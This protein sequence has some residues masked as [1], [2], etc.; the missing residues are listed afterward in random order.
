VVTALLVF[1]ITYLFVGLTQVPRI[2]ISRPAGAL[3]GSV[4]MVVTGVLTLD[5]AF[6]AVDMHTLLLLLG[7]MIITVYLRRAGFFELMAER[8]LSLART[9]VQLLLLVSLASA[10]LSAL[11]VNDTICLLFTPVLLEVTAQ[12]GVNPVP[13]LLALATSSNIGSVMTVTGNPQNMLIGIASGIP[14]LAFL[15]SLAPVALIGMT[16]SIGVIRL[17]YRGEITKQPFPRP[18]R[19]RIAPS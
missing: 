15:R 11:F 17:L 6:A 18:A 2:P 13:Y 4:L 1:L 16:A 19:A 3:V 7:M 14:Y 8:I 5:Q 12:A 9:P 10:F